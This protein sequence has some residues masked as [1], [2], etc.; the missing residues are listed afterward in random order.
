MIHTITNEPAIYHSKLLADRNKWVRNQNCSTAFEIWNGKVQ[1]TN[2]A[3]VA[4]R[5]GLL[6]APNLECNVIHAK[7]KIVLC[8]YSFGAHGPKYIIPTL[9]HNLNLS[10]QNRTH[11][12]ASLLKVCAFSMVALKRVW[13]TIELLHAQYLYIYT[14]CSRA[15]NLYLMFRSTRN[16]NSI[17][18]F[19]CV[20]IHLRFF[21]QMGRIVKLR[22][23]LWYCN[24]L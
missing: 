23:V 14:I 9:R 7:F 15:L 17:Y 13:F 8:V 20:L 6:Q 16:R 19:I 22:I 3:K 4:L 2:L 18:V 11:F 10:V 5:F 24:L 12:H 21:L 1:S